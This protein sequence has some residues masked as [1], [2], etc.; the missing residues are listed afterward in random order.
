MLCI[1]KTF[2]FMQLNMVHIEYTPCLAGIPHENLTP[3][4]GITGC[5]GRLAMSG[6]PLVV[7]ELGPWLVTG[8]LHC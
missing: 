8:V 1:H 2:N 4:H 6:Q 3:L 5:R 7:A